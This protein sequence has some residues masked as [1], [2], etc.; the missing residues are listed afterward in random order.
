MQAELKE[1]AN[2]PGYLAISEGDIKFNDPCLNPTSL[3][4]GSGSNTA[5]DYVNPATFAF[6]IAPTNVVPDVCLAEATYSCQ[7][8]SGPIN[9]GAD[10]CDLTDSDTTAQFNSAD[11]SYSFLTSDQDAFPE[12]TYL[13]EITITIGEKS[14]LVPFSMVLRQP[15]AVQDISIIKQMPATATYNLY[16]P[17]I[18]LF[19][20]NID[21]L[22]GPLDGKPCG[23]PVVKFLYDDG[24]TPLND[25][26]FNH[27]N[28]GSGNWELSLWTENEDMVKEHRIIFHYFFDEDP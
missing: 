4:V 20:Y 27:M 22:I 18:T 12:G 11:G 21:E 15:C 6:P 24:I 5:S 19:S 2:N 28:M 13:F 25:F 10:L 23:D 16:G 7:Y 9:S 26:T 3:T 1:W 14:E 17:M 8:I